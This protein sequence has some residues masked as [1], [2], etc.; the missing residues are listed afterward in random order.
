MAKSQKTQSDADSKSTRARSVP[1]KCQKCAMLDAAQAQ[2]L[3]GTQGD[4]CWNPKVCYSRR[5]YARHR[6]RKNQQ[7]NRQ[8]QEVVIELLPPEIETFQELYYAVLVV[9]RES[10][11]ES[12]VHAISAQVWQGQIMVAL[13]PPIHCVGMV[14]SQIHR[15]V[16]KL[17]ELLENKYGIRKFASLERLD[18]QLCPIRPCIHH[19]DA[20]H[21]AG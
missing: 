20:I 18:P 21:A 12:V 6:D 16:K 10:A 3:H 5:S 8:R 13:V 7:R 2:V 15:Y 14:P 1:L 11:A 4:G 9:Y 19:Q 17:L